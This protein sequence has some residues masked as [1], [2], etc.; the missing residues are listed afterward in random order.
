[1]A[2]DTGAADG[3]EVIGGVLSLGRGGMGADVEGG[4][5]GSVRD[6]LDAVAMM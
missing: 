4:F 3:G 2:L 1:M 6:V 5:S